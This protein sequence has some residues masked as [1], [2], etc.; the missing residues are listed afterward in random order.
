MRYLIG[1][2]PPEE[3]MEKITNFQKSF[4]MNRVPFFI[5]P[6][7]TVKAQGGLTEDL[8]WLGGVES[9]IAEFSPLTIRFDGIGQFGQNVL[10]RR[11]V[12]DNIAALR[13]VLIS[14]VNPNPEE[15]EKYFEDVSYE[16]HLT[17]GQIEL[18]MTVEEIARMKPL[19]EREFSSP[20]DFTTGFL[21]IYSQEQPGQSYKKFSDIKFKSHL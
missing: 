16:P 19:A 15:R 11:V 2:V 1:V 9:A 6:H 7:I 4:P 17:L 12:S 13:D 14:V 8:A 18:G 21:R 10:F 3:I 20:E 5:E